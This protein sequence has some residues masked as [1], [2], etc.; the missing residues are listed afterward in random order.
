MKTTFGLPK[1]REEVINLLQEAYA[2]GNLEDE[3]YERRLSD[4]M[5]AKS[6]EEL[7]KVV[8][9]FPNPPQLLANTSYQAPNSNP[10]LATT[11]R[12]ESP[13]PYQSGQP[14]TASVMQRARKLSSVLG[15][16][17][18]ALI[19]TITQPIRLNTVLGEQR[20]DL[21]HATIAGDRLL[22]RV[23][24]ILGETVVDL[25][26]ERFQDKLVHISMHNLLG[27]VK[28]LLPKGARVDNQMTSVLG[29]V[30]HRSAHRAKNVIR[31]L[32][33]QAT[34]SSKAI[35]FQV[36]LEGN[37]YLGNVSIVHG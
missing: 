19:D 5:D 33:G 6:I 30:G 10:N 27:E 14:F 25:R 29:E 13:T 9:D 24:C 7:Q 31:K 2:D 22:L 11:Q 36:V 34:I 1:R 8:S 12:K 20:L 17:K 16:Q 21:S 15:S 37:S 3:D 4:A 26:G 28:L 18:T 23:E 32:L 35:P